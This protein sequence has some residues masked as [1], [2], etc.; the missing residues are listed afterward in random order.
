MTSTFEYARELIASC[1]TFRQTICDVATVADAR[2]RIF[3]EEAIDAPDEL[4]S[5][6]HSPD[7]VPIVERP[8]AIVLFG[9]DTRRRV[10]TGTW[11]CDGMLLLV[12]ELPVPDEYLVDW[13]A[14]PAAIR[15][16]FAARKEWG[17]NL[18]QSLRN[19]MMALSGGSGSGAIPLLNATEIRRY[20]SPA[21]PEPEEPQDYIGFALEVSYR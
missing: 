15:N 16:T 9:D 20:M 8:F 14:G 1:P 7:R 4:E 3:R 5:E 6:R 17:E 2:E 13:Q 12:F 11:E 10:G 19:D 18:L 21:D